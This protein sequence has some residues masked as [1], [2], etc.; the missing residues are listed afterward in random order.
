MMNDDGAVFSTGQGGIM[1]N[2]P[3]SGKRAGC[4]IHSMASRSTGST[5]CGPRYR[6]DLFRHQRIENIIEAKDTRGSAL[7][8]LTGTAR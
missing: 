3:D 2:N 7:Y 1:W 4:S 5:R 8:R 6:R